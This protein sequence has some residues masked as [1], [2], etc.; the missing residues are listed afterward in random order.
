MIVKCYAI[1]LPPWLVREVVLPPGS[2][3][4]LRALDDDLRAPAD[5]GHGPKQA[6]GVGHLWME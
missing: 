5:A 4:S 1:A 3:L 6:V 2:G